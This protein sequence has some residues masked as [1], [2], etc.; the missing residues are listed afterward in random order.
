MRAN[1]A[2]AIAQLRRRWAAFQTWR[3]RRHA[4]SL[5]YEAELAAREGDYPTANA[6]RSEAQILRFE[7]DKDCRIRRA[8]H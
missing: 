5:I 8:G 3:A 2:R 6:L 1:L 4:A 7:A